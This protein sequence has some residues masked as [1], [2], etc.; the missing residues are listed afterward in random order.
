MNTKEPRGYIFPDPYDPH[1][2]ACITVYVPRHAFYLGAFWRSY[3]FFAEWLAW[4]RDPLH[5]GKKVAAM[6]RELFDRSRAEF[7]ASGGVCMPTIQGI[8]QDALNPCAIQA[9]DETGKWTTVIDLSCCGGGGG[10]SGCSDP[11]RIGPDGSIERYDPATGKWKPATPGQT[12]SS[13]DTVPPAFPDN[14]A[15]RCMGAAGMVKG[16]KNIEEKILLLCAAG[17]SIEEQ[18]AQLGA[19]ITGWIGVGW[20]VTLAIE[21]ISALLAA[22]SGVI[23]ATLAE[24][25]NANLLCIFF[26]HVGPDGKLLAGHQD[27]LRSDLLNESGRII[28]ENGAPGIPLAWWFADAAVW[29]TILG[30]AGLDKMAAMGTPDDADECD[31]C[32]WEVYLDFTKSKYGFELTEQIY[33]GYAGQWLSGQGWKTGRNANVGDTV[34]PTIHTQLITITDC[35]MR[36]LCHHTNNGGNYDGL[37]GVHS[38]FLLTIAES[39][40]GVVDGQVVTFTGTQ[41]TTQNVW[42]MLATASF[43]GGHIV[44]D[45]IIQAMWLRATG[46]IPPAWAD[47]VVNTGG[48][49]AA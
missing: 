4:A 46:P 42:S 3:E 24:E 22:G 8:R 20:P 47:A 35:Q 15:G 9:Q 43:A 36:Y 39:E 31:T 7:D 12:P 48:L 28:S 13:A 45:T 44:G 38:C 37:Q 26:P 34:K 18:I 2:V 41:Q 17:T 11:L 25:N 23:A 40:A 33:G 16:V 29:V 5:T 10:G 19:I 21:V 27:A 14:P 49:P 30:P 6:W 32:P 1:D